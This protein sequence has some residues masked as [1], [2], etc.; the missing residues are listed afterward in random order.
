[1]SPHHSSARRR[2]SSVLIRWTI[3]TAAAAGLSASGRAMAGPADLFDASTSCWRRAEAVAPGPEHQPT[4]GGDFLFEWNVRVHPTNSGQA[5][6]PDAVTR[7]DSF[8]ATAWMDDHTGQYHIYYA[9]SLDGGNNWS[10]PEQVDT[11]TSGQ[12]SKFVSL[13]VTPNGV[14]VA[15]WEDDR[16]GSYNVY[17][18]KRDP[19]AGGTPWTTNVRVNTAGSP[20]SSSDFMNP[21]LAILDETHYYVAWTDWREGVFHQVYSRSSSDGGATFGLESRVSDEQGYQPVAGDPCLI[22]DPTSPPNSAVLHCVTNDWRGNVPGGR[23]PNVYHYRSTNGGASWSLGVQLNDRTD[24]Y[25]Q[26]SSHALVRLS[27]GTL[28]AGWLNDEF[29]S[30]SHFHANRSTNQG[31]TWSTSTQIDPSGGVGTFSSLASFGD[32]LYAGYDQYTGSWNALCSRSWDAGGYF[33]P[34]ARMDDDNTGAGTANPVL[35][36]FSEWR[37]FGAWM[38]SRA[39]GTNWKIYSAVGRQQGVSVS[40]PEPLARL[41]V[42]RAAPNPTERGEN[43]SFVLGDGSPRPAQSIQIFDTG[44]R[45][46]RRLEPNLAGWRWDGLDARGRDV[47]AGLYRAVLAG[48][49]SR[50][51]SALI[52]RLGR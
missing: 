12:Y 31:A 33:E 10:T 45:L 11:R 29:I 20:P 36:A 39:P 34:P 3:L 24:Y 30:G 18:S 40:D 28:V 5:L 19:G 8:V 13:A 21:S 26:V 48:D 27:N 15:V 43:V 7:G 38:D 44:G 50:R 52:V 32:V 41:S 42:L 37:V 14:P 2:L 25:Q 23:Y 49:A 6:W 16:G 4:L 17:L 22:V 1:M 51:P 47:P 35:A 46:V 9:Q